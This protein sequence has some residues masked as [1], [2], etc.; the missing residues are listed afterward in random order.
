MSRFSESEL[1][2]LTDRDNLNIIDES[3]L[4]QAINDASAEIDSY[5]SHY[6]L[7]LVIVPQTLGR[8][9]CDMARYYLYDDSVNELVT[10]RYENALKFLSMVARGTISLGVDN[11][12]KAPELSNGAVMES[13][14]RVFSRNDKSFI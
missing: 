1:I 3:V 12:G 11:L 6:S 9:S 2:Q 13:G 5:L 14:G 8:I 7:P 4:T 10:K